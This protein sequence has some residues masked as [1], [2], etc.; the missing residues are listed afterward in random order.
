[1]KIHFFS[2]TR[3]GFFAIVAAGILSCNSNSNKEPDKVAEEKNDAK[4]T[5]PSVR[6]ATALADAFSNS[7]FE[8]TLSDSVEKLSS[9][10]EIKAIADSMIAGHKALNA[11][12][13]DLAGK[14]VISLP[15]KLNST[16]EEKLAGLKEKKQ[17]DLTKDYVDGLINDHKE[18]I[19]KFERCSQECEDPEI[20]SLFQ[21][22]LPALRHHLDMVM[23]YKD[24]M[25]KKK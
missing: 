3:Y 17:A 7:L 5:G 1:M 10:K 9:N 20:K 8:K 15:A 22:A 23:M 21:N 13:Q 4:F 2:R 25:D 24:R 6:D 14:K 16:Q 12:I 19:S 18:A 11:Q